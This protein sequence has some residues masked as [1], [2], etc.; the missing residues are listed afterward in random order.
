M[1][2]KR[3]ITVLLLVAIGGALLL[4]ATVGLTLWNLEQAT[5]TSGHA[6]EDF[7]L[8]QTFLNNSYE[9]LAVMDILTTESS[10]VFLVADRLAERCRNDLE[11]LRKSAM[12][13]GTSLVITVGDTFQ[14]LVEK[15]SEAAISGSSGDKES[16][17]EE[18][19]AIAESYVG[20]LDELQQEAAA[21]AAEQADELEARRRLAIASIA[22]IGIV[23]LAVVVLVRSRLAKRLVQPLQDLAAAAEISMTNET[24]LSLNERGPRE[25]RA[26]TRIISA[27]AGTLVFCQIK[28]LH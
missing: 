21:A 19:D 25:V 24:P 8:V 10:G 28:D 13:S 6:S 9:L 26:L 16:A 14:R 3:Y 15:G 7:Q 4:A 12:F 27:F 5:E 18:F 22:A 1:T 2:V 17:L 23:Y 20:L 11:K